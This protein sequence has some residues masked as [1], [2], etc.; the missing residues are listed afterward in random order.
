M[1]PWA[2]EIVGG[3]KNNINVV[4]L[5]TKVKL[6]NSE[7]FEEKHEG[8]EDG[9]EHDQEHEHEHENE[10]EH[11]H[12]YDPHIWLNPQYAIK[13]VESIK[14]ELCKIDPSNADYYTANA[15]SYIKEI[16]QLDKEFEQTVNESKSKK[17]AFGGAFAYA[18]F[19]ERY[20]LEFVTAYE[21]CGENIEPSTSKV[22]EVIDYIKENK[23]PVVFYKEYTN[24]N[25]AKTISENTG[26]KALV[27]NTVH[28]VS[29][30]DIK[31]NESYI[32]I[33]RKNLE[34]LKIALEVK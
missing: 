27:F 16:E 4:D 6:I 10:H 28:N 32:S 22:K 26:A 7:E 1:E 18:Y 24:G 2:E 21:A 20:N 3:M 17:I 23:L 5:S 15:N 13:M 30:E 19:I 11:N 25:V 8:H 29:K 14:D 12:T 33:M 34:N 31:N 9:E